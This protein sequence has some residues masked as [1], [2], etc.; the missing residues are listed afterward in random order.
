[1][2][3]VAGELPG[4]ASRLEGSACCQRINSRRLPHA[5][6][7]N[8]HSAATRP[9]RSRGYASGAGCSWQ[10]AFM[11]STPRTDPGAGPSAGRGFLVLSTSKYASPFFLVAIIFLCYDASA[12]LCC[13]GVSC[14]LAA[15]G[16]V[17][18]RWAPDCTD[19]TSSCPL[20]ISY[21]S[22][23]TTV[24]IPNV[25]LHAHMYA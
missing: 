8:R 11:P 2:M 17:A 22:M 25:Q 16:M 4:R 24:T 3:I 13:R 21:R 15:L 1:M 12:M 20:S 19:R 18:P 14:C 5:A 6:G 23:S 7:L 9:P 10:P